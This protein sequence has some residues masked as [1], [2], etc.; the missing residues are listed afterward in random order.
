[1][2][3]VDCPMHPF[4][5]LLHNLDDF[6]EHIDSAR[7]ETIGEARDGSPI[8]AVS[9]G[10][11]GAPTCVVIAG[12]HSSELTGVSGA[13]DVVERLSPELESVALYVVPA[14]D[15][16]GVREN[17]SLLPS[18][19]TLGSVLQLKSHRD[20]EGEFRDGDHPEAQALRQWL[21]GLPQIDAFI[22]LHAANHVVPGGYVYLGGND[23]QM[24]AEAATVLAARMDETGF[25]RLAEDPTGV[26]GARINDGIFEL[27]DA[28]GSCVDFVQE[29]F[30]PGVVLVTEL[31]VGLVVDGPVELEQLDLWKQ[32]KECRPRYNPALFNGIHV[33]FSAIS[34]ITAPMVCLTCAAVTRRTSTS[35]TLRNAKTLES[36]ADS[37]V[38]V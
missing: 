4:S 37:R 27:P 34:S 36:L 1:M 9:L 35:Y 22:S 28:P 6:L 7:V 18:T 15:V 29:A 19:P 26:S 10:P 12:T 24:I 23:E 17:L 2:T 38:L 5:S 3:E 14:V 11:E 30:D 21:E 13:F 32:S 31:P 25:R 16:A 20:L 8:P 33:N